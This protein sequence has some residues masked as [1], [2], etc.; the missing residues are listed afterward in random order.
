M[1]LAFEHS[2]RLRRAALVPGQDPLCIIR[3]GLLYLELGPGHAQG[4]EVAVNPFTEGL[5]KGFSL[6]EKVLKEAR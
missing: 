1:K 2:R 4:F 3:I 5:G 6:P